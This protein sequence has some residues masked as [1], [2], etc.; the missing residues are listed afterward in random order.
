[1]CV[2]ETS[3]PIERQLS[4]Q[5]KNKMVGGKA[6][7]KI[8]KLCAGQATKNICRMALLSLYGHTEMEKRL[9]DEVQKRN[10]FRHNQRKTCIGETSELAERELCAQ[11][12]SVVSFQTETK[13]LVVTQVMCPKY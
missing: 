10:I 9:V 6:G 11:N 12:E 8:S 1:M 4:A 2:S 7:N 3:E 5:T 13:L